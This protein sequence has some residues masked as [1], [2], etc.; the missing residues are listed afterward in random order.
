MNLNFLIRYLNLPQTLYLAKKVFILNRFLIKKDFVV[1]HPITF[2]VLKA[3]VIV[4]SFLY[5]MNTKQ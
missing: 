2:L 5:L 1:M 4:L 3:L